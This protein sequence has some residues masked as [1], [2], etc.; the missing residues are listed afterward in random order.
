M[1]SQRSLSTSISSTISPSKQHRQHS[2]FNGPSYD[3]FSE[4]TIQQLSEWK[5]SS[6][7]VG[8]G[9]RNLG[10]SCFMNATLQCLC[11]TPAFQNFI[12]SKYHKKKCRIAGY[13]ILCELEKL[14][15]AMLHSKYAQIP[16]IIFRNL[17]SL[18]VTLRAG[19]QE[20]AHEF[21]RYLMDGLQTS[22]LKQ[23]PTKLYLLFI[24]NTFAIDS[25]IIVRSL[26]NSI[27][28]NLQ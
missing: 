28:Y 14:L 6:I 4:D 3:L 17:R 26:E 16:G 8:S 1:H 22:V 7:T 25:K 12:S 27:H 15:P 19:R 24:Q 2:D 23:Q 18:S 10:N 11:Y 5:S 13:C 21:L 9:L 20:D